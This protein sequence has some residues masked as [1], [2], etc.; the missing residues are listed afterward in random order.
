MVVRSAPRAQAARDARLDL[1]VVLAATALVALAAVEGRRLLA[2]GV[3]IFLAFPPLLAEWMP[4]TGAGT[5]PAVV[6]AGAVVLA[7][8][9]LAARLRWRALLL[10]SWAAAVVWTASLAL[11]DGYTDGWVARLT[12]RE[13][14][15]YDVPRVADIGVMLHTFADH[16]LTDQAVHWTTHVGAH[17]PGVF[18]LFVWLDR[19]GLG[20]GG[21]AGLFCILV[22]ASA[23]AAVAVTLRALGD[24]QSARVVLPFSVLLPGAVWVGVSADGMFAGALAWGVALL[25]IGATATGARAD[26]AALTG[27]ILLGYTLFLSYGLVLGA[28]P[29]LAVVALTRRA[30]PVLVAA[31]GVG[32]VVLAFGVTGFWWW[33]GFERVQVIYAAS[34]AE[35]RPYAYFVWAN[36]AA[37]VFVIGPAAVVGLRRLI[38]EPRCMPVQ[39]LATAGLAAV[40]V[41]DLS[42]LSK[43]EVERIWLPFAVW[44]VVATAL[45]PAGRRRGW[46]TAQAVLALLVNHLLLTVW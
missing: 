11:V 16:I 43:G 28:V 44:I 18:L 12:S 26:L 3:E 38:A 24:E 1:A 7:G 27:G 36:L 13:E 39:V 9:A 32:A 19:L 45:L 5:V 29:A 40:L 25:A 30:R 20:G 31:A 37:L 8:P 4:H 42:G 34:I 14:Y 17:P 10:V 33:T 2:A 41:A 6:T 15:L 46:L 21:F 23:V 22:G 35:T